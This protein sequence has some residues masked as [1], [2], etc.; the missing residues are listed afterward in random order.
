M[1]Y[2][3]YKLIVLF[4]LLLISC[5]EKQQS[6]KVLGINVWNEGEIVPN[7]FKGIVDI[8][9]QTDS[10]VVLLQEVRSQG[11]INTLID[12]LQKRGKAYYGK[13]LTISSALMSK[14]PLTDIQSSTEL[15]KDSYAFTKGTI[16]VKNQQITVYSI[17]LDWLYVGYYLGRG[18]CGTTWKKLDAP[19]IDA[20][21][22]LRYT[23][24]SRRIKE[25]KALIANMKQEEEK[26][27]LVIFGG[28]FNE[29]SH[30]DWQEESKN[31][32]D[33]SGMVINWDC[34][35]LL[36]SAGY[37]D[38]YRTIYPNSVTHP[39]FTCNAGNKDADPAKL[40][41]SLGV[42]DR[43]R[44]D[45]LYYRPSTKIEL[46]EVA[47]VGPKE[48]FYDGK[49]QFQPTEDNRIEQKNVWPSDHKA[50]FAVFKIYTER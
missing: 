28:D 35:Q 7:G 34:S 15:G 48:D 18:Y 11:T 31:I 20:D 47:I 27:N 16:K 17:H 14:Y 46:T 38:T 49:I 12:S 32:R 25:V 50:T 9:D 39:G 45:F 43:E 6:L 33:H 13:N 21:S 30:L 41:W 36:Q 44:I 40:Q 23:A 5:S 8:I 4:S 37:K 10:D 3:N 24:Q 22:L 26:G 2:L 42:D 1:K 19:V 29:P